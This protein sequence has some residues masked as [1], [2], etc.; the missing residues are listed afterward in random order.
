MTKTRTLALTPGD[1]AG[2]GPD[3]VVMLANSRTADRIVVIADH[4]VLTERAKLL[5]RDVSFN[6]YL[7][8][9]CNPG[10]EIIH[11]DC[12]YPVTAGEGDHR[13]SN[14]LINTLNRAV[15]GCLSGE[16]DALVTGPVNKEKMMQ[17]GFDFSGHTEYLAKKS[18]AKL[19]VMLLMNQSLKVALVTTHVP[20][21]EVPGYISR[22][23]IVATVRVL[24]KDLTERFGLD[25]PHIGV[26][27][28][29]PHAGEGGELGRE[30]I[31]DIIPAIDSLREEGI[32]ASGPFPADTI[33]TQHQLSKFDVV[34]AMYHDQ[35]LPVIKHS[36]FGEIV[37]VTLGLPII[38]TSV[39]HGT[40][41]DIA[42]RGGADAGSLRAALTLASQL[43]V[44]SQT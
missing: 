17:G 5:G 35:G 34:L 3:L 29:N 42:G 25:S 11:V 33:F 21:S 39:D 10:I 14:Y 40:A 8:E 22:E 44:R 36:A 2:I 12:Q 38:R 9:E 1:P 6:D 32:N 4:S 31:T 7:P 16:F 28:L 37:N 41:Y 19:P 23:R 24:H 13:H 18:G 43:S 15:D 20:L 30:E 27:G 26:C